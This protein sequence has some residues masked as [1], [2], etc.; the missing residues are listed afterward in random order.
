MTKDQQQREEKIK[1]ML[2]DKYSKSGQIRSVIDME[3]VRLISDVVSEY[4]KGEV[5]VEKLRQEFY[6][7]FER[8]EQLFSSIKE[9]DTERERLFSFFLTF[10]QPRAESEAWIPVSERLPEHGVSVLINHAGGCGYGWYN[11][12]KGYWEDCFVENLINVTHWQ[13]LPAVP[14]TQTTK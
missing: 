13:P 5:D 8:N 9:A 3:L 2:L 7:F 12:E 6:F 4:H 10:L 11:K 1:A 14:K